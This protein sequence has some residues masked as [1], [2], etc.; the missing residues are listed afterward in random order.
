MK[1]ILEVL[2]YFIIYSF[3]GWIIESAYKSILEKKLIN[4]GFLHGPFCPIYGVGALI[5]FFS[6]KDFKGNMFIVFCLGF[7]VLSAWEYAVGVFL[8][9]MFNTKYWDYSNYKYNLQ[10]R[11]CLLNSMFWGILGVIFIEIIHP[12]IQ[13]KVELID[14]NIIIGI[15]IV[16]SIYLIIDCIISIVKLNTMEANLNKLEELNSKIKDKLEEIKEK[17]KIPN[18]NT[19]V[20]NAK[21]MID[22]LNKKK[23]RLN[24]QLYRNVYRLKKAFPT[25]QSD[26]ISRILELKIEL[27]RDRKNK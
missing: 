12:F 21:S 1:F 4:S 16:I 24:R 2:T 23:N 13:N 27:K 15:D 19:Y 8:E 26:K 6:L 25:M 3:L 20:E 11:V 5:M 22:K 10:G 9:K 17:G 18:A 14:N 7:V